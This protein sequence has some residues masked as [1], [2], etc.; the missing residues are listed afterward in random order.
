MIST[1]GRA[2]MRLEKADSVGG[3]REDRE[4]GDGRDFETALERFSAFIRGHI[5]RFGLN[6]RGIDPEDVIQDIKLKLW[7]RYR[8]EKNSVLRASYIKRVMD[9]TLIDLLRKVRIQGEFIRPENEEAL[10]RAGA[11][12]E[13]TSPECYLWERIRGAAE[14]LC[15]SR[16][17]VVKLFL[18]DMTLDEIASSL[19]WSKDKT[20]NLLYRGID[21]LKKRVRQEG[22]AH[23]NG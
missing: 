10:R 13:E 15:E 20:R 2:E 5:L 17:K 7:K 11:L 21:D 8:S 3:I 18:L 16:R 4:S 1:I 6:R 23:G 12:R 9:S 19:N 22:G 14:T